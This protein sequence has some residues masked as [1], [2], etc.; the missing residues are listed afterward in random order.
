MKNEF[1]IAL[2]IA[3][4]SGLAIAIVVEYAPFLLTRPRAS[5][6]D[7]YERHKF[8]LFSHLIMNGSSVE[9]A[10]KTMTELGF[11]FD[12]PDVAAAAI[13]WK[14]NPPDPDYTEI[15]EAKEAT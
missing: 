1:A 4:Y 5:S 8:G 10:R 6:K 7:F 14:N 3:F 13:E 11:H 2:L 15:L 12:E 9:D